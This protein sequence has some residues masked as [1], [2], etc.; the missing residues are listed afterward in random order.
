MV[1]VQDYSTSVAR[2]DMVRTS[3]VQAMRFLVEKV[4]LNFGYKT[5]L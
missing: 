1:L 2:W 4:S 5:E 3:D